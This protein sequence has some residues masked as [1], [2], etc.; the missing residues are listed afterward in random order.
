V[1][2]RLSEADLACAQHRA[3]EALL[4]ARLAKEQS[5]ESSQS[6]KGINPTTLTAIQEAI[7]LR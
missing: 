3:Q 1:L 7:G 6:P 2:A 4:K 5:P